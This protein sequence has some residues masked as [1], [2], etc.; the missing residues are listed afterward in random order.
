MPEP[1]AGLE[2]PTHP[3][4]EALLAIVAEGFD[5]A[6]EAT[7]V[8]VDDLVGEYVDLES[9]SYLALQRVMRAYGMESSAQVGEN[10]EVVVRSCALYLEAFCAGAEFERRK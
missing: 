4:F 7:G 6:A 2:Q 8:K 1:F 9:L 10:L 3:D 5:R